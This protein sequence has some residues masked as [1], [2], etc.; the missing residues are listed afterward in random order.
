MPPE[1]MGS[2]RTTGKVCG[3]NTTHFFFLVYEKESENLV[4]CVV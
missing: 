4:F 2:E 3:S 1:G